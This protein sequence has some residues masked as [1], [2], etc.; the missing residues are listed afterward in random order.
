MGRFCKIIIACGV[1]VSDILTP[2]SWYRHRPVPVTILQH[3]EIIIM[4]YLDF[5]RAQYGWTD[6]RISMN[7]YSDNRDCIKMTRDKTSL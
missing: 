7:G 6:A 5:A 1:S 4:R 3:F 2:P